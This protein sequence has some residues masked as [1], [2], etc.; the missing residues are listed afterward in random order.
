MANLFSINSCLEEN[1]QNLST[2]AIT[3]ESCENLGWKGTSGGAQLQSP[4]H[5][6][7][8]FKG[9]HSK[10]GKSQRSPVSLPSL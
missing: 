4:A 5:S 3:A 9:L 10:A 2:P 6:K 8:S 7:D 1:E